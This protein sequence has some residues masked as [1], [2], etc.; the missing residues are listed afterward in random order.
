MKYYEPIGVFRQP[1]ITSKQQRNYNNKNWLNDYSRNDTNGNFTQLRKI[2]QDYNDHYTV[3]KLQ[4]NYWNSDQLF[5]N[6]QYIDTL[7]ISSTQDKLCIVN[8]DTNLALFQLNSVSDDDIKLNKLHNIILPKDK[9]TPITQLKFIDFHSRRNHNNDLLLTGHRDGNVHMIKS[10]SNNSQITTRYNHSKYMTFTNDICSTA[11]RSMPIRQL[12]CDPF[13]NN[14]FV[15]LINES[16]FMYDFDNYKSPTYLNHFPRINQFAL[17]S[18]VPLVALAHTHGFS[19][20]DVREATT[21]HICH[22]SHLLQS[23]EWINDTMIATGTQSTGLIQLFDIRMLNNNVTNPV[24]QCHLHNNV[25]T[26]SLRYNSN[27]R[28]LYAL[29]DMGTVTRWDLGGNDNNANTCTDMYLK[30]GL[31]STMI[32]ENNSQQLLRAGDTLL[33][34]HNVSGMHVTKNDSV[35]TYGF[36][37]LSLHRIV[38]ITMSST[39]TI[40]QTPT[41]V[42]NDVEET[43]DSDGTSLFDSINDDHTDMATLRPEPMSPIKDNHSFNKFS[44]KNLSSQTIIET[45]VVV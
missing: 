4:S 36:D 33:Q 13:G 19:L 37:E 30:T 3:K 38:D 1:A 7:A 35:I 24:A 32:N 25:S 9:T 12:E 17:T 15:S 27:L 44:L 29:D 22:T 5:N 10:N 26:K 8:N 31:Q 6:Q 34:G 23:I 40:T 2:S 11:S 20:L 18:Q 39:T 42:D 21:P 28:D 43:I 41:T 16:L 14:G 45:S